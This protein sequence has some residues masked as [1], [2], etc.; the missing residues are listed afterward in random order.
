MDRKYCT[1]RVIFWLEAHEYSKEHWAY[2]ARECFKQAEADRD[3]A[4]KL[5]SDALKGFHYKFRDGVVK[6]GNVLFEFISTSL[7]LVD[8]I[9]VSS[10][11]F[12]SLLNSYQGDK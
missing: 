11:C 3:K 8:W 12:D 5:L 10:R 4:I 1:E 2:M 7:E 9:E 6:P